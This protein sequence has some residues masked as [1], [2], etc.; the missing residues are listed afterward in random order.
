MAN[1]PS[2]HENAHANRTRIE[3]FFR[4]YPERTFSLAD[5]RAHFTDIN[6]AL[7]NYY[8]AAL[9]KKNIIERQGHGAYR[10]NP[11]SLSVEEQRAI[12]DSH[13]AKNGSP[14]VAGAAWKP[15]DDP[16]TTTANPHIATYLGSCFGG[17]I[18]QRMKATGAFMDAEVAFVSRI[19]E[20]AYPLTEQQKLTIERRDPLQ[21]HPAAN[22]EK[23]PVR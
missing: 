15:G 14:V 18:V 6:R 23:N 17:A 8:L 21:P 13:L 5:L 12:V 19:V 7:L 2:S 22:G 4:K 3:G 10:H 11:K 1:T 20:R 9:V 16:L